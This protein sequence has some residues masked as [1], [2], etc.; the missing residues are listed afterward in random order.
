MFPIYAFALAVIIGDIVFTN[1]VYFKII[2]V[3]SEPS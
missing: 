1:L 3:V 2:P